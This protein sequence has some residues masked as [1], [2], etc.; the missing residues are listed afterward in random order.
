MEFN[1]ISV[2]LNECIE[3]LNI[4][5][6][7]IYVDGTAGGGGHSA[8]ILK[9]LDCGKLISIDRD[10]DAITT[11]SERFKNEPNSIIINGCFGDM[12]KL[13]NDRGIYQVDGVLLDIGVSS[14]QLDTDERGFSFHKDAPLDMRMSQSGTSAE[15]LVNDLSYE[16][17]RDIIY[18]YGEDKF[19]PSIAKGI[20]KAREEERITTTLQLAEIIKNSVP[21]KVRREGHPARK[22]FQA[23]RIE[24]NGELTQLENGLDEAFEMLSPKGRLAVI[25][26]HS[27][28]DRIV[29]QKMAS[30][31]KG[32]TCPKDFP[33]CVCGNV[34]KA[35]LVNRKPIEATQKELD[36]NPRSR[37]AKLRICEKI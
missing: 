3:G 34:P 24:V 5:P 11:I 31:C 27:L 20:V 13:L 23:L 30:W 22:T 14:H 2:L 36:K 28:E 29:K 21:Q 7:G 9:K 10:P 17:L 4:N 12:K 1:H 37:S 33:V 18:R 8:E 25:S 15:D 35:K 32:C 26:F 16:E 19:A 6:N